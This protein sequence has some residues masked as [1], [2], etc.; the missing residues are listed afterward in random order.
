MGGGDEEF[1]FQLN[2]DEYVY[3]TYQVMFLP[4]APSFGVADDDYCRA[5][6]KS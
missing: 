2:S 3:G 5:S 4:G 6:F 1:P